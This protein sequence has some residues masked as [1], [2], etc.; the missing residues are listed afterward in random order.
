[1][2]RL[3]EYMA[4]LDEGAK[5]RYAQMFQN[6]MGLGF[7]DDIQE[8]IEY[9]RRVL[10]REDR[11]IWYLRLYKIALLQAITKNDKVGQDIKPKIEKALDKAAR[12]LA[13]KS[14]SNVNQVLSDARALRTYRT[15]IDHFASLFDAIPKLN[16]LQ[17]SAQNP[18]SLIAEMRAIENEYNEAQKDNERSLPATDEDSAYHGAEKLIDF[19]DGFAW[20]KLNVI[21]CRREGKAMGHCGNAAGNNSDD[22][23]LSLRKRQNGRDIPYLTFIW[24]ERSGMLGE[25]KGRAN[26]KPAERYHKYIIPLL[27]LDMIEGIR[28]GGYMPENNFSI[29]DLPDDV[30]E[31]LVTEKPSL[32]SLTDLYR[33]EGLT[34]RVIH[35]LKERLSD[36]G[37][38]TREFK[39]ADNDTTMI[40]DTF[41]IDDHDYE[42]DWLR[43]AVALHNG[44]D[45]DVKTTILNADELADVLER[46][47]REDLLTITRKL[48]LNKAADRLENGDYDSRLRAF[49]GSLARQVVQTSVGKEL[50]SSVDRLLNSGT[51]ERFSKED[52]ENA[53]KYIITYEFEAAPWEGW[54]VFDDDLMNGWHQVRVSMRSLFDMLDDIESGD[55]EGDGLDYHRI[56]HDGWFHVRD[57]GDNSWNIR[58]Y[59]NADGEEAEAFF[60]LRSIMKSMVD[61]RSFDYEEHDVD[62]DEDLARDYAKVMSD[63]INDRVSGR[64]ENPDQRELQFNSAVVRLK[65]LAGILKG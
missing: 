2:G 51:S 5:D 52:I 49:T 58:K 35:Q 10:K 4:M 18:A 38:E 14:Q 25:M 48:G 54:I 42:S 34:K 26:E 47:S 44:S 13:A 30:R 43:A 61:S 63:V 57:D 36:H 17:W 32:A 9:V 50:L 45:E 23:V 11:I 16:D 55:Y 60:K 29:N 31:K 6:A 33:K 27:R 24:N 41:R 40:V 59:A 19:G 39:L 12:D 20:W 64:D 46:L 1:M 53:I 56:R 21:Y 28:G 3:F 62:F 22:N 37:I 15:Q 65:R 8:A 7:D